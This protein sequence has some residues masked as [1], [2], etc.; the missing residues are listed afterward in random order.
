MAYSI[1]EVIFG[2]LLHDVG[3]MCQRAYGSMK[4]VPWET[5]DMES[6]LCPKNK[7]QAYTHKHVL[8]TNAFFD[9]IEQQKI[10]L[11]DGVVLNH[12]ADA[13]SFHHAPDKAPEKV[14]AWIIA[15]A[16]RYSS[17]MDRREKDE[18]EETSSRETYRRLPLQSVFD[19]IV[20][21]PK[22]PA[23]TKNAY[24]LTALDPHSPTALI[25]LPW[26][27]ESPS[28]PENYKAVAELW[29]REFQKIKDMPELSPRLFEEVLLGLLERHTWAIPSS[30]M[31]I[32]DISL[33]DHSRTT[34][35]IAACLYRYHEEKGELENLEAVKN[36][37]LPKFQFI[38]G[39]LSGLQATLFTLANQGVKGVSKI[40]RAR[41][42]MLSAITEAAALATLDALSLPLSCI[43]QQAGGRFLIL[44]PAMPDMEQRMEYLQRD[45]DRWLLDNY[46]GSL[47]FHLAA[48][49]SFPGQSFKSDGLHGIMAELALAVENA[50]HRPLGACQQ[51]AIK[52]KFPYDKAC[53]TC[54]V[55]PAEVH[56]E[57][58]YRCRTCQCEF[59]LGRHLTTADCLVWKRG[60]PID[61]KAI[62][63]LGLQ[64]SLLKTDQIHV[65][66][67]TAV[68]IRSLKPE[69]DNAPWAWRILANHIPRFSDE[70]DLQ[71]PKYD[72]VPKEDNQ[73]S[74]GM[75]K[76]FAHIGAEAKEFSHENNDYRGKPF[77]GLLK[78]DV[79]FLGYVFSY[80][81]KREDQQKSRFTLSRLAQLSRMLDLY[82][83]GYLQGIIKNDFP[84]TYTIY[85]G[86]DDLL[87]IGPWFQMH[88]LAKRMRESFGAYTGN[89]PN[90]TISAGLSLL[91]ANYPVNRAVGEAE[92]L[93]ERAKQHDLETKDRICPYTGA[94][95]IW[96]QF[97]QAL[98]SAQWIHDRMQGKQ[99]VGT[100]FVY[101]ILTLADDAEEVAEGDVSRAGWRAKLAYHLARNVPGKKD[102]K[103]RNIADWLKRLGLDNMFHTVAN[104]SGIVGWRL[105]ITIALY[106]NRK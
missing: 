58:E 42:F 1:Y 56:S 3:K 89:N 76:T 25:P 27:G 63:V 43:V 77:L 38:A 59:K 84:D 67:D 29:I 68:S 35:A 18:E 5:Y 104:E 28:L 81:L 71:D 83:T 73:Y 103:A 12:V 74:S 17:G 100:G 96:P 10:P 34:A 2:A 90:L 48:S 33:F 26:T 9:W 102:E 105:P 32:P 98:D 7:H 40:L 92:E 31:D 78:A 97:S 54:G 21:D 72:G 24:A 88:H 86:G 79:D 22:R 80:G 13:A 62:P 66:P 82:F 37:S 101:Q 30:T 60:R 44:A 16:D 99:K 20:I 87:L 52:R 70:R 69:S 46:T 8:F 64:L 47:A 55:R 106:R 49:P 19:E 39:D 91:H 75:P 14:M 41:S 94:P 50:K 65:R 61:E 85:A 4:A 6:T 11:P 45:F 53:S 23:P 51:G 15:L 57:D 36:E 95:M 93:L